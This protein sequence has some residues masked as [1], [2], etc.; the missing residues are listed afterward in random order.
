MVR[1]KLL[2]QLVANCLDTMVWV[3]DNVLPACGLEYINIVN[4][5]LCMVG[6]VLVLL[7]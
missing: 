4:V 1:S 7:R 2:E 6:L 3:D 5:A